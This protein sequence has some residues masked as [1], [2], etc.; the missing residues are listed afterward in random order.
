VKSN[1]NENENEMKSKRKRKQYQYH[2][3][4]VCISSAAKSAMKRNQQWLKNGVAAEMKSEA[5]GEMAEHAMWRNV[6]SENIAGSVIA[7]VAKCE[8]S[9][10]LWH[11]AAAWLAGRLA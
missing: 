4:G 3:A 11:V 7:S 8:S 9:A 5:N 1:E 2:R 10:S 6:A